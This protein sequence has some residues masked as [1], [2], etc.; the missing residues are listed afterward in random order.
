MPRRGRWIHQHNVSHGQEGCDAGQNFGAPVGSQAV[1]FKVAFKSLEHRR[2]PVEDHRYAA[3]Q[4][5]LW[6]R[7][8][9]RNQQFCER[10][11]DCAAFR[12]RGWK[13]EARKT[14]GPWRAVD[15]RPACVCRKSTPILIP[16]RQIWSWEIQDDGARTKADALRLCSGLAFGCAEEVR[17]GMTKRWG[18]A[19]R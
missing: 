2:V 7:A 10:A 9:M 13:T 6:K 16:R 17:L 1:E 18:W 4:S 5:G 19:G 8:V 14:G 15:A 3:S 11:R 12:K